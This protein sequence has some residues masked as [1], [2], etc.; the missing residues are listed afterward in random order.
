EMGAHTTGRRLIIVGRHDERGVAAEIF[1]FVHPLEH[2]PS[3]IAA[4][5]G[6]DFQSL[7]RH[8]FN[9]RTN[10]R[11]PLFQ[12]QRDRFTCRAAGNDAG[13]PFADEKLQMR[14]Q[15]VERNA[16]ARFERG[17]GGDVNTFQLHVRFFL[18]PYREAGVKVSSIGSTSPSITYWVGP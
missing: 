1:R 6:D 11:T 5:A 12:I 10:D 9:R 18:S 7:W 16:A 14:A 4:A 8:R 2:F 15:S 3:T 17:D 13:Y